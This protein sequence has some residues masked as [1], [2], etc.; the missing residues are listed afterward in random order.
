MPLYFS[1]GS[2]T[3]RLSDEQ[4][5]SGLHAALDALGRRE[6]VLALPPDFTRLHSRAGE[7]TCAA[8]DY[9]GDR[10]VDVMPA[11]EVAEAKKR[12]RDWRAAHPQ[13]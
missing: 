3:T 8:F 5:R 12:L 1:E 6:R 7:L 2:P 10:L 11:K 13:G 9:Y 4:L